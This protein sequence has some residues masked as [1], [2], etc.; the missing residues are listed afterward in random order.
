MLIGNKIELGLQSR[1]LLNMTVIGSKSLH[2]SHKYPGNYEFWDY[3]AQKEE[4]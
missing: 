4:N 3:L 1:L 2:L